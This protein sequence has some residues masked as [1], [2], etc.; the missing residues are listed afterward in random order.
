[1][2][3]KSRSGLEQVLPLPRQV[4]LFVAW[5]CNLRCKVCGLYGVAEYVPRYME[6]S[7][8]QYMSWEI[9]E[10]VIDPIAAVAAS[11]AVTFI[12]GEPTLHPKLVDMVR[13]VKQRADAHVDMC[14]NGTQIVRI[15]DALVDAGIDEVHVSIDGSSAEVNDRGRG[16][17][18]F[19]QALDGLRLLVKLRDRRGQGPKVKINCTVTR[20]NYDDILATAELADAEGVDEV[21]FSLPIFVTEAEGTGACRAL[22]PLGFDFR[23]WRG[24]LIDQTIEGIDVAR[25][26]KQLAMVAERRGGARAFVLPPGYRPDELRAY[27]GEGWP[28][29]LHQS[30][31]PVQAFRTSVLPNGDVTPCTPFPD[32]VIGNIATQTLEQVW[33]SERY[34]RFRELVGERLLP[35]CHRCCELFGEDQGSS[36]G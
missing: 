17:G 12:G 7:S 22:E 1:M 6:R 5:P 18:S 23:S 32:V 25:L 35:V 30:S 29:L 21:F 34:D 28:G 4:T 2:T 27:F 31:C 10:R 16:A 33:R 14:T 15:G 3:E 24:L 19:A 9:F 26:E 11:P 20:E 13:Y 8:P 36:T